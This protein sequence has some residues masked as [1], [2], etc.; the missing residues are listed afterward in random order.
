MKQICISIFLFTSFFISAKAADTLKVMSYNL[1]FGELSPIEG[2][3]SFISKEA[4]DIVALQECDWATYR[5]NVR[6]QNGVR[7]VNVLAAGTGMFGIYGKAIDFMKG[8][9]GI[10]I[11]SKFP[12]IRSERVLLPKKGNT[13]QRILLRSDIEMPDNSIIT[14]ICTHL[15]ASSSID[16]EVQVRF[17]EKYVKKIKNPVIIAG[18]FNAEPDSKEIVRMRKNWADMTNKD[19]TFSTMEP[20]IKIDYIFCRQKNKFELKHTEVL[21]DIKLSDHFPIV[22]EIILK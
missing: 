12:I 6:K 16:R 4:P 9:Y 19:L 17:I 7:V 10:G 20:S 1:R 5:E 11:L 2:I 3:A 22:S 15:E 21:K 8:Y 14:F 13:E 18:D